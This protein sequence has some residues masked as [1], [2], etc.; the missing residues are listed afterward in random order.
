M[1]IDPIGKNLQPL[2]SPGNGFP[3]IEQDGAIY[4][5]GLQPAAAGEEKSAEIRRRGFGD[6]LVNAVNEVNRMQTDA[7]HQAQLAATGRAENPHAAV[8]AMEKA[9]LALDMTVRVTEKLIDAYK[10]VSRM[11]I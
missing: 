2:K 8:I 7:D 5:E 4:R 10:Q 9:D 6:M 11:Q 3:G 1:P